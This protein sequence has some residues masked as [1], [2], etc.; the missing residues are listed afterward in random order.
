[1]NDPNMR[2][3][4]YVGVITAV[5]VILFVE[6]LLKSASSMVVWAGAYLSEGMSNTVYR[7][8]ALGFREKFSFIT[9]A[10]GISLFA[11]VLAGALAA[12]FRRR[13]EKPASGER[14]KGDRLRKYAA[15]VLALAI[16]VQSVYLV[17]VNFADLQL[18]ASFNQRLAALAPKVTDQQ[19]K[20]LRAKWA[21]MEKRSDYLAIVSA[22][23]SLATHA[24]TKLPKPL[25]D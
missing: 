3:E 17:G 4:I 10:T 7:E 21:L 19:V 14:S 2:K 13:S 24:G 5:I 8:A 12:R 23:N 20:E 18:N 9:L 15:I 11:G 25:W 6:P 1:M 22:M 16:F